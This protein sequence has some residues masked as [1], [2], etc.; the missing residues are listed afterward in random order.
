MNAKEQLK[1]IAVY[2]TKV[3]HGNNT[4]SIKWNY[5]VE[6]GRALYKY[7]KSRIP[8]FEKNCLFYKI[9]KKD[10][11]FV[12]L[13]GTFGTESK[14]FEYREEFKKIQGGL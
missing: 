13:G 4:Y 12:I 9:K 11:E 5:G 10:K 14:V 3:Y 6:N 1:N 2:G 8:S 7:L